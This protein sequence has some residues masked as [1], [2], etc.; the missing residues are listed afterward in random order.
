MTQATPG[1][2][3]GT[4]NALNH[5][6]LIQAAGR[7]FKA[8]EDSQRLAHDLYRK[9]GDGIG[10]ATTLSDLGSC[11]YATGDYAAAADSFADALEL[12]RYHGDLGGEGETLNKTG[13]LLLA[14]TDPERAGADFEK[15]LDIAT[16][17]GSP[18]QKARALEGIGRCHIQLDQRTEAITALTQAGD[19]YEQMKSVGAQRVREIVRGLRAGPR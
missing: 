7:Q 4:A 19:I 12:Y 1:I 11:Q 3:H 16:E 6:G 5:L 2:E 18:P 13:E 15:A 17:I 10:Q 8:A 14:S 9:Y